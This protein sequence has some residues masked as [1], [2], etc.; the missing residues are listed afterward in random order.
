MGNGG[1]QK[2]D[3]SILQASALAHLRVRVSLSKHT[4]FSLSRHTCRISLVSI[5]R[6]CDMYCAYSKQKTVSLWSFMLAGCLPFTESPRAGRPRTPG[7]LFPSSPQKTTLVLRST[8]RPTPGTRDQW[9][10]ESKHRYGTPRC[11]SWSSRESYAMPFLPPSPMLMPKVV[12]NARFSFV[13][14]NLSSGSRKGNRTPLS[15]AT[16][17]VHPI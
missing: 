8:P 10:A 11:S 5:D 4:L 6:G 12:A 16:P 2:G 9:S 7:T 1:A 13:G 17:L 15:R 3:A 14:T